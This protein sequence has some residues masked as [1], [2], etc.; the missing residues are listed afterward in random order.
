MHL[1]AIRHISTVFIRKSILTRWLTHS[2]QLI[3]RVA[4]IQS[5]HSFLL[6]LCHSLHDLLIDLLH[7]SSILVFQVLNDTSQRVIFCV[8]L[9]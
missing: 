4:S 6:V 5:L 7:K 8:E 1:C 2:L 3:R 9:V